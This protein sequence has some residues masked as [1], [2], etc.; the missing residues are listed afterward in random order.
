MVIV[1]QADTSMVSATAPERSQAPWAACVRMSGSSKQANAFGWARLITVT[2]RLVHCRAYVCYFRWPVLPHDCFVWG[3]V[4]WGIVTWES[5]DADAD[6]GT[7]A[8]TVLG[9]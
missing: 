2:A 3:I 9:N 8:G 1:M 5:H 4:T 7:D 6:A